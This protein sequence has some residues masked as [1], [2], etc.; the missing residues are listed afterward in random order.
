MSVKNRNHHMQTESN[1]HHVV[2]IQGQSDFEDSLFHGRGNGIIGKAWCVNMTVKVSARKT[3]IYNE[4]KSRRTNGREVTW[5]PELG[6]QR[7]C[8]W[9]PSPRAPLLRQVLRRQNCRQLPW[10]T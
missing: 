5:A 2:I 10:A 6:G 1:N 9:G 4:V 7:R 8:V 3:E